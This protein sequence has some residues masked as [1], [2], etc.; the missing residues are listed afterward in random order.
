MQQLEIN[1]KEMDTVNEELCL[2]ETNE[3][4]NYDAF[5]TDLNSKRRTQSEQ[6]ASNVTKN[7]KT[8]EEAKKDALEREEIERAKQLA[9]Q[10]DGK[11]MINNFIQKITPTIELTTKTTTTTVTPVNNIKKTANIL[12]TILPEAVDEFNRFLEDSKL[13]DNLTKLQNNNIDD[14]DNEDG[15][16]NPMVLNYCE[17]IDLSEDESTNESKLIIKK[18]FNDYSSE[19][20][21]KFLKPI[22]SS[23]KIKNLPI[24]NEVIYVLCTF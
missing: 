13:N 11:K 15:N 7:A 10:S 18:N 5:I 20:D 17:N 21:K 8:I 14:S 24:K 2:I 1:A 23:N 4:G 19:D 3:D 12:E 22:A 16:T 6:M 9:N